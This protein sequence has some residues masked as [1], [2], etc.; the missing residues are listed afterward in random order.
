[1]SAPPP[2]LAQRFIDDVTTGALLSCEHVKLAVRRQL[3]DLERGEEFP[4]YFD[5]AAALRALRVFGILR[6]TKGKWARQPFE[7]QPWQAFVLWV[8]YGWRRKDTGKRRFRKAYLELARKGGKTEFMAGNGILGGFFDGEFGAEVYFVATKRDQARIGFNAAQMMARQLAVDSPKFRSRVEVRQHVIFAPGDK[9]KIEALSSDENSLDGSSPSVS[10]TDEYHQHKTDLVLGA[11][12]TGMGAREQPISWV[13][14][15]AGFNKEY[16]CYALRKTCISI[17]RGIVEDDSTFCVI[18]TLD[19]EDD[20]HDENVWIK[21]N[22]NIGNTPSWEYMRAE[23][24]SAR[25]RG[26]SRWVHFLTKNLNIWTDS[27]ATWIKDEDWQAAG[28][29]FDP[30]ELRGRVCFGGLDLASTRDLCALTLLFPPVNEGETT[31]KCLFFFWCPE[32]NARERTQNDGVNYLNWAKEGFIDLTPGNVT[33]YGYL[34][35]RIVAELLQEYQIHTIAYDRYNASQLV[36]D[37]N[38]EVDGP[39]RDS[40]FMQPFGQGFV[41]MNAPTVALEL[42]ILEWTREKSEAK[43]AD[44]MAELENKPEGVPASI[45]AY[46]AREAHNTRELV[47]SLKVDHG[48]NPV[49]RWMAS[50]VAIRMDPAGNIK[51]DKS[52]SSE[53][54]DGMVSLVM[55]LGQYMTYKHHFEASKGADIIVL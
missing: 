24:V 28:T 49:M 46:T 26:G 54:V 6:H 8:V 36:I 5:E 53:K 51:I 14:T 4:Y 48:G 47:K 22:P 37:I 32:D 15:T 10:I 31:C 35:H 52:K 50:N 29:D 2:N 42:M 20:P 21:A 34:K 27:A 17:L 39:E 7:L 45:A 44:L 12:E 43:H 38:A 19:E 11:M 33:D 1:M 18:F 13:I 40:T 55:A 30:A 41:S 16:P 25:N 23:Y 9:S 3:A